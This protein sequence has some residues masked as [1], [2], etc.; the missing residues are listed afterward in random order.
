MYHKHMG[1]PLDPAQLPTGWVSYGRRLT[2][3]AHVEPD[4]TAL[5]FIADDGQERV[6]SWRELEEGACQAGHFLANTGVAAGSVV[7]VGLPNCVEHFFFTW[8]AWK[9]GATVVPLRSDLPEWER[10]RVLDVVQADAVVGHWPG[11]VSPVEVGRHPTTPHADVVA[12]PARAIASGGSTGTPKLIVTPAPA[13]GLPGNLG[14]LAAHLG[15]APRQV[16]LIPGPL[17][18]MSPFVMAFTGLFEAMPL[19]VLERFRA[20]QALDA[21]ERHRVQHALLVPT[22]LHRMARVPGVEQRDFSSVTSFVSGGAKLAPWVW[23][24]WIDI[25][26]PERVWEGYGST[27][28]HGNTYIR[29]DEWLHHPGS[30]GRPFNTLLRICD[31]DGI[32]VPAGTVGEIYMRPEATEAPTFEYLG[33]QPAKRTSDGL[34]CVGDLGW[35][36]EDGYL[37]VADRRADMIITGGA[38]VYPAEVEAACSEHPEVADVAVVGLQDP[39]WGHRL[40]AIVQARDPQSPPDAT[41]LSRHCRERLSPYKVPKTFEFVDALPR[42]DAGKIQ[43]S[44]LAAERDSTGASA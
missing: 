19:V 4:Q 32:E 25:L 7:A 30:V 31:D 21:I 39:D 44:A 29:G 13:A 26:G 33:G 1:K 41:E 20:E 23:R 14:P 17:Y 43:R 27:E 11:A 3:L 18:H 42:N 12:N 37:F 36:D 2:D 24:S 34:T 9:I 16:R 6:I 28:A 10:E 22:M 5:V 15:W 40:H 38:N 8:G 35:V